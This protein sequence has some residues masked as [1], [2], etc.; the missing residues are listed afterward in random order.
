MGPLFVRFDHVNAPQSRIFGERCRG[1]SLWRCRPVVKGAETGSPC[2]FRRKSHV[3]VENLPPDTLIDGEVIVVDADGKV[4]FKRR[5]WGT[6]LTNWTNSSSF[7]RRSRGPGMSFDLFAASSSPQ[8]KSHSRVTDKPIHFLGTNR[9]YASGLFVSQIC[10]MSMVFGADGLARCGAGARG[11]S[12]DQIQL[13]G[14]EARVFDD[15]ADLET[16]RQCRVVRSQE[17]GL[18]PSLYF[19]RSMKPPI[20]TDRKSTDS[21]Q[22]PSCPSLGCSHGI[23]S[24]LGASTSASSLPSY[25]LR[26]RYIHRLL[27]DSAGARI[28]NSLAI[29]FLRLANSHR[30]R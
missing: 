21:G 14:I 15:L 5:G 9:Q 30:F 26:T 28:A 4:K 19:F 13:I 1:H 3:H 27:T 6:L 25:S 11:F 24:L 2:D 18:R 12:R 8:P 23:C 10:V 29:Y 20:P 22:T 7:S 17:K 16:K